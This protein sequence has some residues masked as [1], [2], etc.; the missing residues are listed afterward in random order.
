MTSNIGAP[1]VLC[2][3]TENLSVTFIVEI[4]IMLFIVVHMIAGIL[5]E[6]LSGF[7]PP[8]TQPVR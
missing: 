8:L 6:V 3:A 4:K 2:A 1:G 5:I 7:F